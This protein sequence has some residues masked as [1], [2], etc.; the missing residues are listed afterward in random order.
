[1]SKSMQSA[2]LCFVIHFFVEVF[3][4]AILANSFDLN[5]YQSGVLA[6]LYDT[7]AFAPQYIVGLV[8]EKFKRFN[9]NLLAVIIML[10]G[11][12]IIR[13]SDVLTVAAI[14][15]ISL[16]NAILHDTCAI[17]T[18][19]NSNS[20][21]FPSAFFV[22]GGSFGLIIGQTFGK[23][24]I[25]NVWFL[26]IPLIIILILSQMLNKDLKENRDYP[27][28]AIIN[29]K[30]P[31]AVILFA[32]FFITFVR[33]FVGYAIPIGWKKE[34]W[35]A[36]VL[37]FLMGFG[38]MLGGFL[39]DKYGALNVGIWSSVLCAPFLI[40]GDNQMVISCIGVLIFS[41]TMSIT[42][43]MFLSVYNS[44]PGFAF[45]LTTI[46]LMLGVF[47]A[48]FITVP[49]TAGILL[50]ICTMIIC[51][52]LFGITLQTRKQNE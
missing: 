35:Q 34:L 23:S 1:M 24:E 26:L 10:I 33:S 45:G 48:F 38:K 9:F 51:D 36:F 8:H 28:F 50:I 32:A 7:F 25:F 44:L 11:L 37:F 19:L 13:K 27:R 22:S 18:V 5:L 47:P 21:L 39:A 31:V 6:F 49:K 30:M 29:G 46:P 15:L 4:F 3:C 17:H 41:M 20:K 42:F 43:G 52:A 12:I 2:W 40:F 14:I 16:G